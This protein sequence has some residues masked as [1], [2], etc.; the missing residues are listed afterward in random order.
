MEYRDILHKKQNADLKTAL[1]DM[2]AFLQ[3]FFRGIAD[4]KTSSTKLN[5]AY[6]LRSFFEYLCE[7]EFENMRPQDFTLEQ[8]N[9]ITVDQIENYLDYTTAYE[10]TYKTPKSKE[11]TLNRQNRATGKGRKLS[12]LR[13]MF[14]FFLKRGQVQVNPAGIVATPKV[15]EKTITYLEADETAR[16]LDTIEEGEQLTDRQKKFHEHTKARDLAIVTLLLG[17]G[18]RVSECVGIN[19]EH[20]SFDT[21]SI[22]IT[23]KG[24]NEEIIYFGDEVRDALAEYMEE[25]EKK[26]PQDGHEQA[27]FLS[28]QNRR[29][30]DRAVQKLVKKYARLVSVKNISP[31]KLRSTFGTHLY[32]DTSDIYL[33]AA[34]LGHRDINTTKRHYASMDEERRKKAAKIV[35]LRED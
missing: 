5:Y 35:K 27:F 7:E 22:K 15:R 26:E 11:I 20:I 8:L 30:T 1:Q 14:A 21:S 23:R 2:P 19:L 28:I 33:V 10:K 29:I 6:D 9:K 13:V 25:R 3:Q 17:T 16:L 18:I 4:T 24:G 12:A 34:V 31:H 32:R